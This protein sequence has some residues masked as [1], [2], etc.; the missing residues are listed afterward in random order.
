MDYGL[1]VAAAGADTQSRRMEVLS[2]N[3][4][5]V[6]TPGFKEELAVLQ[7]RSS[8][9]I[10]D[11][12]A[13]PGNRG[14]NDLSSGVSLADTT[15][16]FTAGKMKQTHQPWDVA[17]RGDGFF[18]V[19]RDGEELLTRAGNFQINAQGELR[20]AEGHRV[21]DDA[22]APIV[23]NPSMYSKVHEDGWVQHSG[24]GQYLNLVQPESL[25]DLARV[26][27]NTFRPLG[28]LRQVPLDERQVAPGFLEMSGVSPT[29]SMMELIETSR[30]YEANV[31]M[32]QHHDQLTGSLV[33][34]VL[35]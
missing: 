34:R 1:Y 13:M 18:V 7:A 29:Q 16:N 10:R 4:A 8:R 14:L 12:T 28:P 3:L 32:V 6:D 5:N 21:L 19:Q 2:H 33:S 9:A 26:G 25:G 23:I 15:T 24:G 11:G 22:G 35:K 31:K 30:A 27:E 17:V 20:T